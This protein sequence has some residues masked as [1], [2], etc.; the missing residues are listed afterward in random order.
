MDRLTR[1]WRLSDELLATRCL[2]IVYR[3]RDL[4]QAYQSQLQRE[5]SSLTS[6]Y[7]ESPYVIGLPLSEHQHVFVGRTDVGCTSRS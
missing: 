2:R 6:A 3:W 7:I 1:D 5:A 4:Y